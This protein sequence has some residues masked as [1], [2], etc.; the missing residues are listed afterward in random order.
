[1]CSVE[2]GGHVSSSTF[3]LARA[4]HRW[5]ATNNVNLGGNDD[6]CRS[7]KS[8][9]SMAI[10]IVSILVFF[11]FF[12]FAHLIHYLRTSSSLLSSRKSGPGSH[13]R[14]FYPL[15]ATVRAFTFIA[16]IFPFCLP[17]S[18]RIELCL[19]GVTYLCVE[20]VLYKRQC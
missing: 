11:L 6:N 17:S 1:M 3:I 8:N 9:Q 13:S 12:F 14:L 15:P 2:A 4:C 16:R 10:E 7:E 5:D 18:T 20:R 19:L